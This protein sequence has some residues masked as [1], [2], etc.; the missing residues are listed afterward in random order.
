MSSLNPETGRRTLLYAVLGVGLLLGFTVAAF[1]PAYQQ[2]DDVVMAMIASG[3]GIALQPDAHLVYVNVILGG[4]LRQAYR[5]APASPWYGLLLIASLAATQLSLLH[6]RLARDG[7]NLAALIAFL[8]CFATVA[9]VFVVRVQFTAVAGLAA[10]AGL[11]LWIAGLEP[12]PGD[13]RQHDGAAGL[14]V[15]ASLLL[16]GALLRFQ[17]LLLALVV[18]LPLALTRLVRVGRPRALRALG[19]LAAVL[20]VALALHLGDRAWY[21][22]D[23]GWREFSELNAWRARIVD[24]GA[25]A[26]G[27]DGGSLEQRVGWS[28]NDALMLRRWFYADRTVFPIEKMRTLVGAAPV[29]QLGAAEARSRIREAFDHPAFLAMALVLPLLVAGGRIRDRLQA[30][31]LTLVPAVIV[32]GLLA[33]FLRAPEHVALPALAFAPTVLLV[34]AGADRRRPCDRWW[35]TALVLAGVG[36]ALCARQS[37]ADSLTAAEDNRDLRRSLA[38][39]STRQERLYVDWAGAFRYEGVLPLED[40]SYL[41]GLR[42][43]SLGWPQR[44]PIADRMLQAFGIGDLFRSLYERPDVGLLMNP[45]WRDSLEVYAREHYGIALRF[46]EGVPTPSFTVF[47]LE[48]MDAPAALGGRHALL[49]DDVAVL[50]GLTRHHDRERMLGALVEGEALDPADRRRPGRVAVDGLAVRSLD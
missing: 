46:P 11:A 21:E 44:S 27:S 49:E 15:P 39:L 43:Y 36:A 25:G 6:A 38:T 13:G 35:W 19:G 45:S 29:V 3:K 22:R 10:G 7:G 28:G 40:S 5:W 12:E 42:L 17:A 2:N 9:S 48:R 47:R 18:A 24:Y 8:A 14:L 4:L 41:S 16:L 23:P 37:R 1:T 50:R 32:V 34:A 30:L 33:V 26:V 31:V 20:S